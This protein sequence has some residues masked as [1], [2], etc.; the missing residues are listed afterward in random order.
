MD[1]LASSPKEITLKI[2][3]RYPEFVAFKTAGRE[4]DSSISEP[5]E[6]TFDS[7]TPEEVLEKAHQQLRNDLSQELLATIKSS[8]PRFFLPTN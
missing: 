4:V 1:F 8:S 3:E 6:N 5:I 7:E 2:L